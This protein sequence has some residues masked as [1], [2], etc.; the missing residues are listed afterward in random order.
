[1]VGYFLVS[2]GFGNT[3]FVIYILSFYFCLL[4]QFFLPLVFKTKR[5]LYLCSI[6][7]KLMQIIYI[8]EGR[9][10]SFTIPMEETDMLS[11]LKTKSFDFSCYLSDVSQFY[12]SLI[13][14]SIGSCDIRRKTSLISKSE[15]PYI[16]ITFIFRLSFFRLSDLISYLYLL[17]ARMFV[18]M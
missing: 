5:C 8:F 7:F 6:R 16:I 14:I 9:K 12:F 3:E 13:V 1:M 11:L 17:G 15:M 10:P 2:L 4:L 18:N